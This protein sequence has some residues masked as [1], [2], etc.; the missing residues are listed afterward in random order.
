[1]GA[2]FNPGNE[3][4]KGDVRSRIYVDKTGLINVLNKRID[5]AER[6]VAVS[7]ARRFGKS[8]AAGMIDAYYS[9]GSNSRELFAPFEI[10]KADDFDT[11]LNKYNVIHVDVSSANDY[12]TDGLVEFISNKIIT[13]IKKEIGG[14]ETIDYSQPINFVLKSVYEYTGDSFVIIIDEWDCIIRNHAD[15]QDLVHEY[16]QFLHSL[17][18]SEES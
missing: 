4:F 16:L 1:M 7:H 3:S 2:Y 9:K 13:E 11:Y 8:Q 18:K 10:A 5:T 14:E 6:C 12:F 17:F 15:R